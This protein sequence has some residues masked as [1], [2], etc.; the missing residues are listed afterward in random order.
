M[1]DSVKRLALVWTDCSL[2]QFFTSSST[3]AV[4]SAQF[5]SIVFQRACCGICWKVLTVQ[6]M[7]MIIGRWSDPR[8]TPTLHSVLSRH[9]AGMKKAS[10]CSLLPC[11]GWREWSSR[12]WRTTDCFPPATPQCDGLCCL[13]VAAGPTG[14][15]ERWCLRPQS[16]PD[17]LEGC[18]G[19]EFLQLLSLCSAGRRDWW[20]WSTSSCSALSW[21]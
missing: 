3:A 8:H 4:K 1:R 15:S 7:L 18:R 11:L 16:S 12:R 5:T 21:S 14:R 13:A 6:R 19:P 10:R 17:C 2:V 20:A 9:S